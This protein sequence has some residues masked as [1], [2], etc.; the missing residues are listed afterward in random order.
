[1]EYDVEFVACKNTM[2]T[3]KWKESDFIDDISFTQ[4]GIV[5]VIERQVDGY[6]GIRKRIKTILKE[7]KNMK[8]KLVILASLVFVNY[9]FANTKDDCIK[10]VMVLYMY[11]MSVLHIKNLMVKATL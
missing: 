8:K 3:M 6:I 9:L 2:E 10:K 1:M 11:K 7:N 4:A 5:E